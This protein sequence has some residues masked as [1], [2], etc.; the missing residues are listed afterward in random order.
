MLG[1]GSSKLIL[2]FKKK[3]KNNW[4]LWLYD[5]E[6]VWGWPLTSGKAET[7]L[8]VRRAVFLPIVELPVELVHAALV[9]VVVL[10]IPDRRPAVLSQVVL[11]IRMEALQAPR[12]QLADAVVVDAQV[13][14]APLGQLVRVVELEEVIL[15][16]TKFYKNYTRKSS[17]FTGSS[18]LKQCSTASLVSFWLIRVRS[19]ITRHSTKLSNRGRQ[20]RFASSN[21]FRHLSAEMGGISSVY[22]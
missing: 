18:S 4:N 16:E 6:A 15:L 8:V 19:S 10:K 17:T 1:S 11:I 3:K 20:S 22:M 7:A 13:G 5:D 14:H 2:Q 9:V 12:R 21:R